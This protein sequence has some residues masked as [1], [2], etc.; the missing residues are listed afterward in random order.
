MRVTTDAASGRADTSSVVYCRKHVRAESIVGALFGTM[1]RLR[2]CQLTITRAAPPCCYVEAASS[3]RRL[4]WGRETSARRDV[5]AVDEPHH[6]S[7]CF[8]SAGVLQRIRWEV[9]LSAN[10][11]W[12]ATE[13]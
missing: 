8:I 6:C 3:S 9:R 12:T 2:S 11:E 10:V 13:V 1:L 7:A 4:D 5:T